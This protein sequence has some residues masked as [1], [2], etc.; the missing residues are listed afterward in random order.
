[1]LKSCLVTENK[2]NKIRK[3]ST[4]SLVTKRVKL[5]SLQTEAFI[6]RSSVKKVLKNFEKFTG[7]YLCQS[8]FFNKVAELRPATSLKRRL[9]NR[10]FPVNFVKTLR[11]LFFTEH[12]WWLFLSDF[13]QPLCYNNRHFEIG[14]LW[15]IRKEKTV[16]GA[17]RNE[18]QAS[19]IFKWNCLAPFFYY[20][21]SILKWLLM[22]K[23]LN[24]KSDLWF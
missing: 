18:L 19:Y 1:M 7:K 9:W 8:L 2:F 11:I 24:T 15:S 6:Q 4:F 23:M 12:R 21:V 17:K 13:L 5:L 22:L 14:F 16:I 20:S 10:C 3:I